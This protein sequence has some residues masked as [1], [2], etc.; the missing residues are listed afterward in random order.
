MYC[1]CTHAKVVCMLQSVVTNTKGVL[2]FHQILHFS[3]LEAFQELMTLCRSRTVE[4][5]ADADCTLPWLGESGKKGC[6]WLDD[7][8]LEQSWQER[9]GG[10]T[11]TCTVTEQISDWLQ[12]SYIQWS[13][14]KIRSSLPTELGERTW[15]W[16]DIP[17]ALFPKMVTWLGSP[18]KSIMLSCTHWRAIV[19][20]LRPRLPGNTLSPVER[21]PASGVQ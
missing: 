13:V 15:R 9:V 17:P 3:I 1:T 19:W 2:S 20:S 21:K 11:M 7:G 12:L 14:W 8:S 5:L 6:A 18:P 16:T 10:Y 4:R